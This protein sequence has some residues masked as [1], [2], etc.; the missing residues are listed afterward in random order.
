M[1][2]LKL[3]LVEDWREFY[4]WSS[5]R[6]QAFLAVLVMI[7]G[8]IPDL[9]NHLPGLLQWVQDNWANLLPVLHHFFPS[10]TQSDWLFVAQ[11]VGIL[12]RMTQRKQ[13]SA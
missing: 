4:K 11:V 3:E 6:W 7:V 2:S 10:A 8:H 9:L 5:V 13:P 1:N 12:L